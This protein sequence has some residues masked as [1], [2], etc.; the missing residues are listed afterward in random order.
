MPVIFWRKRD[1]LNGPARVAGRNGGPVV[2]DQPIEPERG[3]P[4]AGGS[5]EGAP[6]RRP[7]KGI[8]SI[9][10]GFR[11][12]DY[13]IAARRPVPLK[14]IAEG[15]GL[16]PSK[17]QFYLVSLTEV[18]VVAQDR[19]TGHYGL[20]PYTLQLGIVGLQ[21]FDVYGA[22]FDRMR[23]LAEET[24][25]TV[26]LGVWGDTGPTIIHR[27]EGGLSQSIFELKLGAVLPLLTSALGRLFMAYLPEPL[28]QGSLD[29]ELQDLS[30]SRM[31]PEGSDTPR[32]RTEAQ[33]MG[34]AI[35]AA[36]LS[37]CRGG[38]LSD[39]T[40]ISAPILDHTGRIL[41]GVTIMGHV[42]VLN[43]DP[44]GPVAARLRDLSARVTE[45]AVRNP[46]TPAVPRTE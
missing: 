44:E 33:E 42:N 46:M 25:H 35:R 41:A 28:I 43:D 14:Q 20:G 1:E 8:Q 3:V 4:P 34:A 13:L 18:G 45:E 21:Q 17:L 31:L 40:A 38:L 39:H 36:G 5:G 30:R 19:R 6:A 27:A 10:T 7:R 11:I 29:R 15:T 2:D 32:S 12:L 23:D 16:T 24:G 37:R 26:F 22:A 9:L